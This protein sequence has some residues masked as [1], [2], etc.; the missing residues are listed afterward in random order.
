MP[1]VKKAA[2]SL[3]ETPHHKIVDAHWSMSLALQVIDNLHCMAHA[4]W[5]GG[6]GCGFLVFGLS[7]G[8]RLYFL[9]VWCLLEHGSYDVEAISASV[10]L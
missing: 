2:V 4:L 8:L 1:R 5:G 7:W 6:W 10:V 9:S 3:S